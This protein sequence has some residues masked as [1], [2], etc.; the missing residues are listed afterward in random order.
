MPPPESVGSFHYELNSLVRIVEGLE[1][2]N[3]KCLAI[4]HI[5]MWYNWM[6]VP[7]NKFLIKRLLFTVIVSMLFIQLNPDNTYRNIRE[8]DQS[9]TNKKT[10]YQLVTD[11][12][13]I[14]NN[15]FL[16]TF[17]PNIIGFPQTFFCTH[18]GYTDMSTRQSIDTK[19]F[20]KL[21][22]TMFDLIKESFS[23]EL[24]N[25]STLPEREILPQHKKCYDW[26][27]LEEGSIKD[28]LSKDTD[29]LEENIL[30]VSPNVKGPSRFD[31]GVICIS[32][33]NLRKC[34]YN[35]NT[36]F[37]RGDDPEL[38]LK[39]MTITVGGENVYIPVWTLF[40]ILISKQK[41]F[42]ILPVHDA[43][44]YIATSDGVHI[45]QIAVCEGDLAITPDQWV[46]LENNFS[47]S[48][49][50]MTEIYDPDEYDRMS[51]MSPGLLGGGEGEQCISLS[52][53]EI[54]I[55][56]RILEKSES[57]QKTA[58]EVKY[59]ITY[60]LAT[61]DGGIGHHGKSIKAAVRAGRRNDPMKK[62]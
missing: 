51:M 19:P 23:E 54:N 16:N 21:K 53:F 9:I 6:E 50:Q 32:K 20:E 41:T 48:S 15:I 34:L 59:D 11:V 42:Y 22:K 5:V 55:I 40:K 28:C 29:G 45:V 49:S 7:I 62:R 14:F 47:R 46:D 1:T 43:K 58:D 8:L 10:T 36:W 2:H 17:K 30:F 44:R 27:D 3:K 35:D 24:P 13:D 26:H 18:L 4:I 33:S 39:V 37:Y 57:H 31:Y 25:L 52:P 60:N 38:Y 61:E 56:N 12:T